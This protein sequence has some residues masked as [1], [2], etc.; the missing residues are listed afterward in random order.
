MLFADVQKRMEAEIVTAL[1][2]SGYVHKGACSEFY[3][4]GYRGLSVGFDV[5]RPPSEEYV[6]KC[7]QNAVQFVKESGRPCSFWLGFSYWQKTYAGR[8]TVKVFSVTV[9]TL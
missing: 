7:I 4:E 1:S 5:D 3:E 8:G 6:T 2:E 9:K